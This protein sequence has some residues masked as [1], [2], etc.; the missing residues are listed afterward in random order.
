MKK[1]FSFTKKKKHPF[2]TPDSAS[3]LSVGYELKDKDLGKVH[4]AALAGDLAK[5]KQLA[6]KNDVN[7]LDKEN[8][9]AL[10]I[11]CAS[12]HVE[13]VH[14]LV[15][16]KAKLNLCDNQNRS[17]LMKAVQGQH[18]NCVSI[19][20]ENHA[21]PNLMD[22]NGN[23]ALHLA[24]NIPSVP[25]AVLLLQHGA[26][27]NSQNKEGF[28]PLIVAVRENHIEMAQFLLK[29]TA[30]VNSVDQDQRS[31]LMIA[32]GNGEVCMVKLLLQFDADTTLKDTK[33]CSAD[34][35]AGINGH[36]SCS[37]LII[38]HDTQRSDR[39]SLSH[40]DLS[41][42]K[43]KML[44]APSQD[45]EA[46]F[47]LGGPA[48]DRDEH[49]ADEAGKDFEDN[50]QSE[51][52]SR[53]SKRAADDWPSS[54]DDDESVLIEKKPLKVDLSKM[55]ASK[56]GEVASAR[57]DT[58]LSGSDSEPESENRVQRIPSLPKALSSSKSLQHPVDPTPITF[59]TSASHMTSTPLPHYRKKEDSTEDEE[60]DEGDNDKEREQEEEE[61]G[62]E[63]AENDQL[64]ESGESC[65]ANSPAPEAEVSKEKKRDFLSELGL[66]GG[67]DDQSSWSSESH[68]ENLNVDEQKRGLN[69]QNEGEKE[70]IKKNL[71]YVPSFVRGDRGNKMAVL[72][73]RRSV[74]R[75][76]VSQGGVA[77]SS[78]DNLEG[79][80]AD[81]YNKVQKETERAKWVPPNVLRKPE[82]DVSRK[83]DLMEE[84]DLGDVD[85]LEDA[86]DWDSAST[87]SMGALCGHRVASPV[88]EKIPECSSSSDKDQDK[89]DVATAA[90]THQKG[91]SPDKRLP[92][93]PSQAVPQPQ[94]RTRKTVPQ[95][96]ESEEE[97]DWETENITS[98]ET[99]END[100][101]LQNMAE[102]QTTVKPRSADPSLMEKDSEILT[103]FEEQQ[104]KEKDDAV[105][106]SEL[107]LNKSDNRKKDNEFRDQCSAGESGGVPWEKR[108][109]KL[110]VEVEKR[111]VKSTFKSVAGELKEKFGELFIS[112]HDIREEQATAGSTSAE[113]DSSDEEDGE[114][115][116]RPTARARNTALITIP[117]QRESG[118]EDSAAESNVNS[119]CE[120]RMKEQP[121]CDGT[122]TSRADLRQTEENTASSED[123]LNEFGISQPPFRRSAPVPGVSGEELEEDV[124]KFKLEVGMLKVVFLDMEKEKA[125]LQK[126]IGEG[127]T[128]I[129]VE[130]QKSST[131]QVTSGI[132]LEETG[133][134]KPET[135][136]GCMSNQA[137]ALDQE[138]QPEAA[139]STNRA[140]VQLHLPV[141]LTCISNKQEKQAVVE[142][143]QSELVRGA[144]GSRAPQTNTHINGDPLCVFDDGTLSE[145]SDDEGSLAASGPKNNK[146]REEV[147]MAEDFDELTQ[148]SDTATDDADSPATGYSHASL[149]IKKLDSATLDSTCVVK[150]QNIFHEYERSIK[151]GKDRH[152]YLTDKVVLLETERRDLK[153]SLEGI[154]D[155][156]SAMERVQ[157]ELQTEVTNLKFQ[158]KQ[159]QENHRHTTMKYSTAAD[160]MR[161]MD[162]EHQKEI[163]EMQKVH[164]NLELE[165]KRLVNN[166][167]Q[168]EQ[169]HNETQRLLA[170]ERS[171]RTLQENLLS[172]HLRKNQEIEE[173]NKR[174]MI[175]SSEVLSQLTEASDR[176]REL[177]QQ[178]ASLQEQLTLLR[179]DFE[180]LQTQSS[181][182]ESHLIEAREI[183][184]EE[185][186]E[187]RRESQLNNET[188][189]QVVFN[190]KNQVTT[191]KS[192]LAITT[193]RLEN[194]R[195]IREKLEEEVELSRARLAAAVKD[196][197]LCLA[198]KSETE[199]ALLREKEELQRLKDRFTGESASQREEV[200]SLS[201]KLA[202]AE[203]Q[204][205][206]MENEVHRTTMQLTEKGV[207]L[208]VLQREKDQAVA[209]V[210]ELEKALQ[211][212]REEVSCNKARQEATQERLV[213]TQ[214]EAMLL[215][216]QLEEAQN[217]G[218]AKERAVTDAQER[219]SDILSK[220]RS[221]CEER[222][223]L[224]EDRNKELASKAVDLRDQVYKLEEDKNERETS[225]RQLQQELA[226]SLKKLSMSEASLEVNTR[227]RNDLEEEKTRLLKDLDRLKG[228]LEESEDEYVQAE[229]RI[230]SL[231]SSLEER[232]KEL[233][234]AAQK[235]QEALSTSAASDTTIKQLEDAVQRLE[236]ENARLEAA[237]KQQSN[238][239]DAL[240]KGA[241]EAAALSG[242]SPGG[243][244]RSHLEDMVTNLQSS[245]MTLEDQLNREVQKQSLLSHTAQDSR[246][247]WEEELKGRS[248]LGVRLAELEK[249][250]GELNSQMEIEK[251]KA[252]KIAEQKKAVDTRLD[253]EIKRNTELQ[254]EMYRLRTLLKTA[255]KKVRDQDAGG[256]EFGSPMSSMRMDLG[257]H[258]EGHFGRMKDRVDDLQV[259]LEKEASL[260]RQLEKVNEELKD[261]VT[262]LKSM[263][264]SNDLLERSKR[265]LEE[266]VLDL[267]RRMETAQVEQSH[268]E[269]YRRDAEERARQ[270]VQQKLEQV[271][272][273]LQSQAASQEALDQIKA[274]NEASLRS[275]LE[276]RIREL[277]GELGRAR[278][279]QQE[280]VNQR[281][282]TR[283]ELERFRQLYTEELHLRKSLAAKLERAN[284]RLAEANS[285]L[286][287]E[288]SRSLITNGSLGAP[289]LDFSSLASP[290]NYGASLGPLNRNLGLGFSLLNPVAEGQN[291]RM[292]DYLA[293]MQSELDRSITKELNNATAELDVASAR[294]SPVG[295]PRRELDPVSRATQQYLE[296][297]KKNSMI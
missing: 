88:V 154:K 107:D 222:V 175:K 132:A 269:Q 144:R 98:R 211:T 236:I 118:P 102:P 115:I 22:I 125:Q 188:M 27:I 282:S 76:R 148:S 83:T 146:D 104:Q 21:D 219:F 79:E 205:N 216:Q 36:H 246:A 204:S 296:V 24:A 186:E 77:S 46:G 158:L 272:L 34:N 74:G 11:A 242:C 95:K 114:V 26:Q 261:Q 62:D 203:S 137:E 155:A 287:N 127:R 130:V 173:E 120:D 93:T 293:K 108:Y 12:G 5:L 218:A 245:K 23:T 85:D 140:P 29:E 122:V 70:E 275:Q 281:E 52:L 270:E 234:T 251:K 191:L 284:S 150:L 30:D 133:M 153:S 280:S 212:H 238:K 56:K 199:K 116:E 1:I 288:R 277:E 44:S 279:S 106:R 178:T 291:S 40:Q 49:G 198:S 247:L 174:N 274:A 129:E 141:Q 259:Q 97:S 225:L 13:V 31:P 64:E 18:D 53:V 268:V 177:L 3:R 149:L 180:R 143:L 194:E 73:P 111:E 237:A 233:S 157:L 262:S 193:S 229:R 166:M 162:E 105:D 250:K 42:K 252:K 221:D 192:E 99:A 101:P 159:E 156:K 286:L 161:R 32:A 6:K 61:E 266:E 213:Q 147:G 86:S 35:Y 89:D 239:I 92:S 43:K 195:Q 4:K 224:L 228:K 78:N 273:F 240:Q 201:Q 67:E 68:S 25:T 124:E 182:N 69:S 2:D 19:L 17:A 50:S 87:A 257:R 187:V 189:A 164:M 117:E 208:E 200:S 119:L 90:L 253:Q 103:E 160:K 260:R 82:G 138:Q 47:S 165:I 8:R 121:A 169:A 14:F 214:S 258:T 135:S 167:K 51:S 55:I 265:Q 271:N 241:Q 264:H 145:V 278:T 230:N 171:A 217:K 152:K 226:D 126:E 294:M 131:S 254:K 267:R 84:L 220:L 202:K 75:P 263:S 210:K 248:K 290:A 283:T 244:V 197:E 57:A 163:Q 28:T 206:S 227:Y 285:K 45:L 10:H 63:S 255:K 151:K 183:L 38:E 170:Q 7:Q 91:I 41:K 295:S 134:G 297:L 243:G 58:S 16:S 292:E 37:H 190:C 181:L 110:W 196:A 249:E 65:D 80:P 123:D 185:L 128:E 207:L 136:L 179:T 232:E 209:R 231:K 20:L 71:L 48:T 256:A 59:L 223:Q 276:Q 81:Q 60:E 94:P 139:M 9:T 100:N 142:T 113:E 215:R 184:K 54:D 15:E 176:E 72:E 33:G 112:R 39:A 109:E 289:S 235:L 168:L 172:S 66:E 96:L